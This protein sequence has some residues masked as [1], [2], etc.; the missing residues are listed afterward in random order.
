M[1]HM[2]DN[3]IHH[4]VFQK[5]HV[6]LVSNPFRCNLPLVSVAFVFVL[7]LVMAVRTYMGTIRNICDV[8]WLKL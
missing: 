5:F 7:S 6:N 2:Y 3:V 8:N 1:H 4:I